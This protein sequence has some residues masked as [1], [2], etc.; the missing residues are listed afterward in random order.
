MAGIVRPFPIYLNG[1]KVAEAMSSTEDRTVNA[2]NQYGVDGVV[3]QSIGADEIKL[4]FDAIIL[5][6][7]MTL[8][9]SID[10]LLGT[11]VAVGMIRNGV[12]MQSSG[13]LS[14]SNYTS[15]SKSGKGSAKFTFIGGE[16]TFL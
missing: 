2:E 12:M 11:P 10:D 9:V 13:V 16:P 15:D 7:G 3:A 8:S 4:D 5:I 6:T 14:T 1:E